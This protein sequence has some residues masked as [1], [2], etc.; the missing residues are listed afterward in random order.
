MNTSNGINNVSQSNDMPSV[1]TLYRSGGLVTEIAYDPQQPFVLNL[2]IPFL[3]QLAQQPRWQLWLAPQY[4]LSR[5]WLT[6]VGLPENKVMQM[7]K[8]NVEQS[9][10]TMEKALA[11]GNFSSVLVWL[12]QIDALTK[13]R[14]QRAAEQGNSYGFIMISTNNHYSH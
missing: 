8:L 9:I 5:T 10:V 7:T 12:P 3:Q 1:S 2:L 6:N 4:K 14:L 11:S 13:D